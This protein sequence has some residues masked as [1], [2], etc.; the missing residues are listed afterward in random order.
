RSLVHSSGVPGVAG[1][2]QDGR[3]AALLSSPPVR[4]R[5]PEPRGASLRAAVP[6]SF[7]YNLV[8]RAGSRLPVGGNFP[9]RGCGAPFRSVQ[10]TAG[11]ALGGAVRFRVGWRH[12][13]SVAAV[14][15]GT[16]PAPPE[17]SAQSEAPDPRTSDRKR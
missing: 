17:V 9:R 6:A 16:C 15:Q 5:A 12:E 2:P 11:V 4:S 7:R 8:S 13:R 1:A 14:L 3:S 10:E